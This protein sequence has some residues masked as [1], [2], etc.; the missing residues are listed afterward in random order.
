MT[1]LLIS[2]A[3]LTSCSG[4]SSYSWINEASWSGEKGMIDCLAGRCTAYIITD[5]KNIISSRKNAQVGDNISVFQVF[6]STGER[7]LIKNYRIKG[8]A[9]ENKIC[10]LN[11]K[12]GQSDSYLIV[13]GCRNSS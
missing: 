12:P 6:K 10:W 4:G 1:K 5:E 11:V 8:I 9:I 2:L 7:K 13:E 3:V